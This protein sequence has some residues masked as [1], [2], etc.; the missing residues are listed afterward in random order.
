MRVHAAEGG[1]QRMWLR[2]DMQRGQSAAHR[3]LT[4][5]PPGPHRQ[6]WRLHHRSVWAPAW[7]FHA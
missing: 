5:T 4:R 2:G 7:P 6:G 1:M 3:Q